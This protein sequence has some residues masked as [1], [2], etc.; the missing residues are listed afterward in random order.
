MANPLSADQH[1]FTEAAVITPSLQLRPPSEPFQ[2]TNEN[3]IKT[4]FR[5]LGYEDGENVILI[6]PAFDL[7]GIY[8]KTARI[9]CCIITDCA[10]DAYFSL[11]RN[12]PR[13]VSGPDS[14]LTAPSYY[15]YVP[16]GLSFLSACAMVLN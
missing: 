3:I 7:N 2:A 4:K 6:L 13:L 1:A 14:V 12:G 15:F 9:T 11:S 5:H 10:W 16:N 8:H